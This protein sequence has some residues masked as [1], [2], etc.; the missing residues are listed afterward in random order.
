MSEHQTHTNPEGQ[1]VK[2]TVEVGGITKRELINKLHASS[3]RLNK[4]GEKLLL[5]DKF[6]VSKNKYH[7]K[8]VELT[9]HSLGFQQGANT[10]DLFRKAKELGLSLCP[11]E[12]GP[13]LRLVYTDQHEHESNVKNQ[14]PAGAVTIA[15]EPLYQHDDFPKGFYLRRIDEEL[16]LRGYTADDLHVWNPEDVFIFC[17]KGETETGQ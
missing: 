14:A 3:I 13:F 12:L 2:R 9:V 15:S 8:T 11:V 10:S 7:L 17:F 16:W 4:Y 5:D 1:F 6:L